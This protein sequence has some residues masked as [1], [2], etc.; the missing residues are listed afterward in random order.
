MSGPL[1][2]YRHYEV[3]IVDRLEGGEVNEVNTVGRRQAAPATATALSPGKA[4]KEQISE[5][6]GSSSHH[7]TKEHNIPSS[8]SLLTATP[9][10]T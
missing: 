9:N 6:P 3:G 8:F 1:N 5:T 10:S 2:L 4:G 7:P